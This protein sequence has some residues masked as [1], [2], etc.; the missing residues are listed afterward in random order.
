MMFAHAWNEQPIC[1]SSIEPASEDASL[2]TI[3][4]G[5]DDHSLSVVTRTPSD[6]NGEVASENAG[7]KT[8]QRATESDYIRQ[9]MPLVL[10]VVSHLRSQ[11]G[12]VVDCD[13]FK[14]IG[15]LGLLEAMRKYGRTPDEKFGVYAKQR[16]RGAILDELRKRDIRSRGDRDKAHA[17]SDNKKKL[18]VH[19]GR[20][21]NAKELMATLNLSS[22]ELLDLEYLEQASLQ[23]RLNHCFTSDDLNKGAI[24]TEVD[25]ASGSISRVEKLLMLKK[26]LAILHPAHQKVMNLYYID[27]LNMKE[28]AQVISV[29]ESRVCQIHKQAMASL[30]KQFSMNH[31]NF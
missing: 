17:F 21:P 19:L 23:Q 20:E 14:Q 15:L 26:A 22:K 4:K 1:Q 11:A 10:S 7:P 30:M 12:S 31:S 29:S 24:Q 16:V 3:S 2:E 13:D 5:S 6:K 27:Q 18:R 9:Y 25:L 28:I 8:S